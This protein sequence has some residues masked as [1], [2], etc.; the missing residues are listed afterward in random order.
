M[1]IFPGVALKWTRL[2]P[3]NAVS[4]AGIALEIAQ[5]N[6][7]AAQGNLDDINTLNANAISQAN[8]ALENAQSNYA[9]ANSNLAARGTLYD[10]AVSQAQIALESAQ[11]ERC[12]ISG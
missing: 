1:P 6:Y 5:S 3:R 7:S 11:V 9:A 12:R 8:I 10:N 4:Q 2:P